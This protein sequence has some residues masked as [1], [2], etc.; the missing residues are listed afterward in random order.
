MLRKVGLY[1]IPA[2][3]LFQHEST[4]LLCNLSSLKLTA[5]NSLP[6][7]VGLRELFVHSARLELLSLY[8]ARISDTSFQFHPPGAVR[9]HMPQLRQFTNH[10]WDSV[11]WGLSVL[12]TVDAPGVKTFS[13]NLG[14]VKD[15]ATILAYVTFGRRANRLVDD[16]SKVHEYLDGDAI[17]PVLKHLAIYANSCPLESFRDMLNAF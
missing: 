6:T 17:Y 15:L 2:G 13:L 12:K 16:H 10:Q 11:S 8:T 1:G 7:L 5:I 4:P 3:F 9:V 14:P